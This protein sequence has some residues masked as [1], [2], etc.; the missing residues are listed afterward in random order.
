MTEIGFYHLRRSALEQALPKLL[1][2]VLESGAR[3]VVKLGSTAR[4]EALNTLLWTYDDRGF[5]PHGSAEDGFREDQPVW[6]TVDDENP[7]EASV[8][9]LADGAEA[10]PETIAGFARCLDI[11]DGRDEAAVAAA[12][13]RWQAC[14]AAGHGVTYWQQ[15]PRGGW[16]KKTDI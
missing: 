5:L 12:R 6:L 8:L 13:R 9:V 7:N 14:R 11:F 4:L 3:A 15:G 16:E 1:E 10:A 2:K